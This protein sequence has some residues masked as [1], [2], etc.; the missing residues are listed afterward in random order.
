MTSARL[1]A[2]LGLSAAALASRAQ[3]Y[4]VN[5]WPA[6]VLQKDADGKTL[7][8]TGAGPFLFSGPTAGPEAGTAAGFRPFYATITGGGKVE[9]DILYPLF[10][11]RHYPDSHKASFFELIN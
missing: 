8:W 4:E 7:S 10:F 9:T 6:C 2:I 11:Y 3:A 1:T 5:Y